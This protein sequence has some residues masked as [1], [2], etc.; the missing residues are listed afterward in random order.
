MIELRD[1][2]RSDIPIFFEHQLDE[3][4]NRMAAFTSENPADREAWDKRWEKLISECC[5]ESTHAAGFTKQASQILE[6]YY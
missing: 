1:V 2:K 6:G 3:E 4:A 5:C